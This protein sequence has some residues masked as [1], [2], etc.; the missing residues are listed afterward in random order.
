MKIAIIGGGVAAFEAAKTARELSPDAEIALFSREAVP[1]YRR[2]ALSRMAAE[3]LSDTQFYIKPTE[4]YREKNIRLELSR[5]LRKFDPKTRTLVFDSGEPETYDKLLL[6]TGARCFLPPVPG[7]SLDGVLSLREFADLESLR[8]RLDAG[9]K[10]AVVIGGGLLGLELAQSLLL[11]GCHVTVVEGCP[12][13]LPRNLDTEA[14]AAVLAT[15]KQI[16]NLDLL[17]GRCVDSIEGAN[18]KAAGVR[19][20]QETIPA[21]LVMISAGIRSNTAE[22]AAAGIP[23]RHGILVDRHMKTGVPDVYAAGDCAE[24]EGACYGLYEPARQ[25]G[26]IA[27]KNMFG[28]E[29]AFAPQAYPARLSV[30]GVKVFS[31]GK[32]EGARSEVQSDPAA[33]T[34]RK[35][36]FDGTDRLIGAILVGDLRESLKLQ[37][38]IMVP[39]METAK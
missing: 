5:T 23:C 21:D 27:A 6:A 12:T 17:F 8:A 1:P 35:L 22:A 25:M 11:R 30:F 3:T 36:F 16:L 24:V 14:A 20:S 33:G 29:E 15:L 2:P 37:T 38:Q 32:L 39:D 7:I 13:L 18:G 28:A 10:Q 31:A 4:F 9:V 19:L 26:A 34:F